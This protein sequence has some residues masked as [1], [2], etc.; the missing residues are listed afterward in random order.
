MSLYANNKG[1][2][3]YLSSK[4][5][6]SFTKDDFTVKREWKTDVWKNAVVEGDTFEIESYPDRGN[7]NLIYHKNMSRTYFYVSFTLESDKLFNEIFELSNYSNIWNNYYPVSFNQHINNTTGIVTNYQSFQ[8]AG[9]G[10][11][12][13]GKVI[14]LSDSILHKVNIEILYY[15]DYNDGGQAI[16]NISWEDAGINKVIQLFA[17]IPTKFFSYFNFGSMFIEGQGK[18]KLSNIK[19]INIPKTLYGS[20]ELTQDSDIGSLTHGDKHSYSYLTD[21][22]SPDI[23]PGCFNKYSNIDITLT[24]EKVSSI[25]RSLCNSTIP[26]N[27]KFYISKETLEGF[28]VQYP[29]GSV[30][31]LSNIFLVKFYPTYFTCSLDDHNTQIPYGNDLVFS[32]SMIQFSDDKFGNFNEKSLTCGSTVVRRDGGQY[33][34][35]EGDSEF[36]CDFRYTVTFLSKQWQPYTL[37][38]CTTSYNTV[39]FDSIPSLTGRLPARDVWTLLRPNLQYYKDYIL[40]DS[41]ILSPRYELYV[42]RLP[43]SVN[44][45]IRLTKE[46]KAK[47]YES[48]I[49]FTLNYNIFTLY[50]SANDITLPI[51]LFSFT[52]T[53]ESLTITYN[54]NIG[55][56]SVK[57]GVT[58][59]T[60]ITTIPKTSLSID[61]INLAYVPIKLLIERKG[62]YLHIYCNVFNKLD[63]KLSKSNDLYYYKLPIINKLLDV[64]IPSSNNHNNILAYKQLLQYD[65]IKYLLDI[66]VPSVKVR[67]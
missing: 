47:E 59:S 46:A 55:I 62:N 5:V 30:R 60:L 66:Q 17:C 14:K 13:N 2:Y 28:R 41:F 52:S 36:P 26:M 15:R 16:I 6:K 54:N 3:D 18:Y 51:T 31:F 7:S 24:N 34:W 43:I 27:V 58:T 8:I 23:L 64:N 53:N 42:P 56:E 37:V 12:C 25:A 1:V 10:Y 50:V 38:E 32:M 57:D 19:F 49:N 4:M 22:I 44:N 11:V 45:I 48:G 29:A 61:A 35:N 63:N 33:N 40:P 67:E 20:I 39:E 21:S 65:V 9:T